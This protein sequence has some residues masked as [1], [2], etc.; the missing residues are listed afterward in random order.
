MSG[1]NNNRSTYWSSFKYSISCWSPIKLYLEILSIA[2]RPTDKVLLEIAF[3]SEH[4]TNQRLRNS[5]WLRIAS[6]SWLTC[7]IWC[8]LVYFSVLSERMSNANLNNLSFDFNFS[9]KVSW[10]VTWVR[11]TSRSLFVR[12]LRKLGKFL[13]W[14]W[15]R[16]RQTKSAPR[17]RPSSTRTTS[18]SA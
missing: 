11:L 3:C 13:Q 14:E 8:N 1:K 16:S 12:S 7:W 2:D 6:G 5:D 10:R 15:S 18:G 9:W 4:C 17:T